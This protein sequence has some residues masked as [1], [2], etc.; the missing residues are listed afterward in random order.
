MSSF[1]EFFF[2]FITSI[3]QGLWQMLKGIFTGFVAVINFPHFIH[4]FKIHSPAFTAIDWVFAIISLIIVL[5]IYALVIYLIVL[6]IRKKIRISATKVDKGELLEELSRMQRQN[7]KLSSEKDKIM[8]MKVAQ[9]GLEPDTFDKEA[10][11]SSSSDSTS[12]SSTTGVVQSSENRF[13]KLAQVDM[14]Y[15]DYT[16]PVFDDTISLEKLCENFRNFACS[17]MHLY[18][19]ITIIRLLFAGMGSTKL[20]L[21]QGISGTGKTSLPYAL[22]KF[23]QNDA[24]VASVQP[25]WRDRTELFGYF[26]EFTKKFNETEVLK[27]IYECSFTNDVNL[28]ILDEMNIARVEYYF[29][30][31]LSVLEMP[32]KREWKIDLVPNSWSSDP[33]NLIDGKLTIPANM[34]YVGTANNDDSTFAIS[35]KVYDRAF[36]INLDSKGIAFDAPDTPPMNLGF[37]HLD[38][39]FNDAIAKYPVSKLMLDKVSALDIYVIEKLRIAFGNRILKQMKDFVP[40]FVA[41]GGTEI[42]GIDYI[43]ANKIFR[44]FESLNLAFIRDELD[45]LLNFMDKSFGKQNMRQSKAYVERLKRMY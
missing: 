14:K 20:V 42:D 4:L 10:L 16:P 21:L 38:K 13:Y 31:M 9:I 27:K 35:D 32:D 2:D 28:V 37:S 6:F 45:G 15:L 19:D 34:W 40:V 24:I 25:S 3:G 22:G 29:A 43:L 23:L 7:V 33:V 1:L 26:N 5:A 36:P 11:A 41:C 18:Y 8:A 39:L 30:E 17:R 12:T 44:K